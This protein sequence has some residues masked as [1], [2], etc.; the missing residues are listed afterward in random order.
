MRR[1][2]RDI[3]MQLIYCLSTLFSIASLPSAFAKDCGS[4]PGIANG[5]CVK[6]YSGNSNTNCNDYLTGIISYKPTCQGNCYVYPFDSISVSGDGTYG[7]NC[8]VYSDSNCQNEMF[9][10]GNVVG[11]GGCWASSGANSMKC[12]YRC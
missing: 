2:D 8:Y 4:Q 9:S 10:T 6:F 5:E 11:A 1:S 12:Y 3:K 7:T